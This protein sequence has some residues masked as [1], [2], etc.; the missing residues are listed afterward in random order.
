MLQNVPFQC[1]LKVEVRN[2]CTECNLIDVLLGPL[3]CYVGIKFVLRMC[4]T[5][6]GAEVGI[7][8]VLRAVQSG[9]RISI[10]KTD[11]PFS[12]TSI[13]SLGPTEP[14]FQG[15]PGLYP[16]GRALRA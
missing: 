12:K 10:G 16:G 6:R 11:F 15:I 13:P 5:S 14:P 9:V 2:R 8:T 7:A 4:S 1:P 3:A